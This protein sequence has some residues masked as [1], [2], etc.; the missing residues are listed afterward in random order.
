MLTKND[1]NVQPSE[2]LHA[3]HGHPI[4]GKIIFSPNTKRW[5]FMLLF[6]NVFLMGDEFLAS[7]II[8]R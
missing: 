7:R 5:R 3:V 2:L 4:G 8:K 1:G 6:L